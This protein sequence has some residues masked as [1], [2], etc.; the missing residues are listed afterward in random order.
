M[1]IE[2]AANGAG[3]PEAGAASA[4]VSTAAR[5]NTVESRRNRCGPRLAHVSGV[6]PAIT[7]ASEPHISVRPVEN[8]CPRGTCHLVHIWVDVG[9]RRIE[10][11]ESR[12]ER[13]EALQA[14]LQRMERRLRAEEA[15]LSGTF[16][17]LSG[18]LSSASHECTG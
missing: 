7:E 18:S 15:G 2:S 8:G 5:R 3:R 12:C 6:R 1:P 4:D 10:I 9:R 14:A 13:E 11:W 16:P 17:R